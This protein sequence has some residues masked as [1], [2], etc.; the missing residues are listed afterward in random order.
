VKIIMLVIIL[1]SSFMIGNSLAQEMPLVYEVENTGADVPIPYLPS[2]GELPAIQALPDPFKWPDGRGRISN[3]SD[4]RYRRTEIKYM[5]EHYEIGEKPV[6]PDSITASYDSGTLTVNITVNENTL[7][8]T[9]AVSLPSGEGPFPAV[10][11]M[12]SLTGS[13]PSN[14]FTSRDIATITFNFGQV[15]A[16]T[17]TRGSEP[18]NQLYPDLIYMGAY[19]AWSWGVSRLIDGL[20]LVSSDLNIDLKHLAVTGCSFAGKMALFAGAFDERIAL[21][22]SQ[23]SGGGGYT[24]WRVSETLGTVETLG[25]TSHA[26]FIEDLFQFSNAVP[27]LPYDHHELMA[28]VAPRA[29]LVTG[30]PDYEWLADESGHVGSKAAQEIW[31]ALGVPDRFGFSIV[32][33][34]SHCFVPNSQIPEIEAF[35]EKFLLGNDTADTD[36]STSPYNTNLSPWINWTTPTLSNDTSF[37]G[38]TSLIYPSNLQEELDTAMTFIWNKVNDATDYI[39]Q[40]SSD[41]TFRTIAQVDSTADTVKTI[42]DLKKGKRYYWR[43]QVKDDAGSLGP[44]SDQWSFLTFIA[45]PALPPL[46]VSATQIPNRT[47]YIKLN[48]NKVENADQYFIQLATDQNFTRII[49][50]ATTSDTVITLNRT[51]EGLNYYWRVRAKNITGD[52]PWSVVANFVIL[53]PPTNLVLKQSKSN[54]V[55]L[56]WQD[57]SKVEDGYVMER[58]QDQQTSFIVLDTLKVSGTEYVDKEI[59]GAETLIYR[60]KA[61]KDSAESDYSNEA[62][63]T[64]VGIKDEEAD[65]PTE[66]SISQNYPNP[67][68]P[69]TKI[70]FAL[71]KTGLTKISIYDL[72]GREIR[73]LINKEI[74]AGYHEININANNF[75]TG[76]LFYRIQSGDFIQTKKMILV[77]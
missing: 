27:K 40:V 65:I 7:S 70:N 50:S 77:R 71:P 36:V 49:N 53:L 11:G 2:F 73:T 62:S 22:I 31:N 55:N 35:V 8:L 13:L 52:G 24:T 45:A 76:V 38:R 67:F 72:L 17:Q 59:E 21:T 44:W 15:M 18:I 48:W 26:W 46:L 68:N 60:I 6:R 66:Y 30:N 33:G 23:E 28:M 37:F 63:L 64:L 56:S 14:I 34:H 41:P 74:I 25:R 57:N 4:W 16:H 10:I 3:F 12:G 39:L 9:S 51:Q 43:I 5:I 1:L 58:K 54:E 20:E 29:L 75:P 19:S 69:T 47:D 32:G 61:Y 42:I